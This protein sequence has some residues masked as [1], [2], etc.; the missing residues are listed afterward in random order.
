M[1][2][3]GYFNAL[4]ELGGMRRLLDDEVRTHVR[5]ADRRGLGSRELRQITEL[6]SRVGST[7][8]AQILDELS[9]RHVPV[10]PGQMRAG[11]TPTD[12]VLATNM[13][14]VGVDV[15]RLGLM[16]VVGQPKGSAEYIQATSRVGRETWA[17]GLV[18]TIYNWARP[19]DL[20]HYESFDHYHATFYRHVEALSVTPFAARALDRGLSAVLAS[21]IRHENL[22]WNPEPTA[23][24]VPLTD[25]RVTELISAIGRRGEAVTERADVAD[26]I[27]D[28]AHHR[29]DAWSRRQARPGVLLT[30]SEDRDTRKPLLELP[31]GATWELWTAP[32]SLRDVE[33]N[34]NLVID[35]R[36]DSLAFE[37]GW[38]SGPDQ[39][40]LPTIDQDVEPSTNDG[41]GADGRS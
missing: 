23:R 41:A 38:T 7:D 17:P 16:T 20:S 25:A 27:A 31:T 21:L 40:V 14:S 34:V 30:Y 39:P 19:R 13:I 10:P 24:T 15:S 28:M 4:R 35:E 5:R 2:L 11:P 6:T 18:F 29:R 22:D 12:V 26:G 3:V 33:P 32:M 1:T 8:I 36:D 9:V 37:G